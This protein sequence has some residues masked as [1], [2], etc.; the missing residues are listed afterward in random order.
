MRATQ[1]TRLLLIAADVILDVPHRSTVC[2]LM[3]GC[4]QRKLVEIGLG[5]ARTR[6]HSAWTVLRP[7]SAAVFRILAAQV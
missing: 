5:L 7:A 6:L 3:R 2:V 4:Q 1:T